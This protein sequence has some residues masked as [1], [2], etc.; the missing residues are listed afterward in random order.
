LLKVLLSSK[1]VKRVAL[2]TGSGVYIQIIEEFSVH[3]CAHTHTRDTHTDTYLLDI[4][5]SL[6]KKSEQMTDNSSGHSNY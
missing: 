6:E 2:V 5:Y 3:E 1:N 4:N